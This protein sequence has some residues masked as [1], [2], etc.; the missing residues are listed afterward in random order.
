MLLYRLLVSLAAPV[1][2][3]LFALRL[4]RG[5]ET[6]EDLRQRLATTDEPPLPGPRLWLHG[7]SNG[8]L[9][10]ARG[11]VDALLA[12]HPVLSLTVTA[13]T[14]TGRDMVTAWALPRVTARLA[15]VDLRRPLRRFLATHAPRAL[16]VIENELWPNRLTTLKARGIPVIVVS[17][18]LS[19]RSAGHWGRLPVVAREVLGS[20]TSLSAQDEESA[21][22]FA[23]LDLPGAARAAPLALKASSP[24]P[25]ADPAK[26][27][28][29]APAFDRDNT[30]L[31]ASTHPGEEEQVL[32]AFTKARQSRPALRLILAP[33]HARRGPEVAALIAEAGLPFATRSAGEAPRSAA[34]FLADTMSEMGLWYALSGL[35]FTGGSLVEKGGHTPW[36][37]AHFGCA[38]LH[39]PSSF[40]QAE[41]FAALDA[42]GGALEVSDA[43]ALA[44]AL[45]ELTPEAQ[46]RM[47]EIALQTADARKADLAPLVARI[48]SIA[49]I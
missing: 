1:L 19:A 15:P 38:L 4:M 6:A 49:G 40:N 21:A 27:A 9:A 45:A 42:A 22:R 33:R 23:A 16:V 43:A 47:A 11:L 30:L 20:I 31:A 17:A 35:C 28:A 44:H 13:N 46:A 25:A 37:P 14:T 7:A 29:L 5:R 10:A 48:A 36:E 34:V 12:A 24:P 39:G 3:A 8:E 2:A 26:L 18:R 41:A 32:T